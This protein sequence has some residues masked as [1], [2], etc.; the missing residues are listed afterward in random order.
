MSASSSA[1]AAWSGSTSVSGQSKVAVSTGWLCRLKIGTAAAD[2]PGII[3]PLTPAHPSMRTCSQSLSSSV[4][5]SGERRNS[6]ATSSRVSAGAAKVTNTLPV[7]EW[8]SD[9]TDPTDSEVA[10][11]GLPAY[12][13]T[14]VG[15]SG[16]SA[17]ISTVCPVR[18][19]KSLIIESTRRKASVRASA[20]SPSLIAAGPRS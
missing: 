12:Q 10:T 17:A 5:V 11:L 6:L 14:M 13:R 8:I 19:Q 7:A 2:R 16:P 3:V 4:L 15:P 1:K 20:T 9:S 18:R